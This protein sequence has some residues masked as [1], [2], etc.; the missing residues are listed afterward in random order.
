M[1]PWRL[2]TGWLC[3]ALSLMLA[4]P[5]SARGEEVRREHLG[6]D[7]LANLHV[8]PGRQIE[9][10]A[11]ALILHGTLADHGM[12]IIRTLQSNLAKQGIP[13]LAITLSLGRNA[14]KGNFACDNQHE[15][16]LTYA[17]DELGAW[18]EWLKERKAASITLVGHSRGGQRVAH[19]AARTPDPSVDRLL[20]VAP[21]LDTLAEV[22]DRYAASYGGDLNAILARARR[23]VEAGDEDMLIDVPGFLT[24]RATKATA[25][26]LVEYYDPAAKHPTVELLRRIELPV[27]VVA[28][29]DDQ[30]S[31]SVAK[32]VQ[33][34]GLGPQ[35]T[36]TEISGADHFFRD[37][38]ADDL[39]EQVKAFM[40][41][42]ART[43]P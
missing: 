39:A 25:A 19:Y 20:L 32:R 21:P 26:A 1:R 10:T 40:S 7:L 23:L 16:R 6:L 27:H 2:R 41:A 35:I 28:G 13:S 29:S 22:S 33:A 3:A 15:H 37:I 18:I 43:R 38:F 5:A 42:A 11:V 17:A 8:P 9:A 4:L 31:R 34:A 36:V 14:R 24:C 30:I 12:E